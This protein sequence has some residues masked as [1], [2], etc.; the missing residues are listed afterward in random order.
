M[1]GPR[2]VHLRNHSHGHHEYLDIDRRSHQVSR[3][4]DVNNAVWSGRIRYA[5]LDRRI[6]SPTS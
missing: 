6:E 3:S 5:H 4:A 2:T 1:D